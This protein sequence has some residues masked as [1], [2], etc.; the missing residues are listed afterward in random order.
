MS[1]SVL[2][3]ECGNSPPNDSCETCQPVPLRPARDAEGE[4]AERWRAIAATWVLIAYHHGHAVPLDLVKWADSIAP[5]PGHHLAELR[6]ALASRDAGRG[7]TALAEHLERHGYRLASEVFHACED[8]EG[9]ERGNSDWSVPLERITR[10][11]VV[12]YLA[13]RA[14][15]PAPSAGAGTPPEPDR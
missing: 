3:V 9:L 10:E 12:Q 6:A 7:E 5:G 13:A 11:S 4:D 14:A 1:D 8:A 15:L 2:C